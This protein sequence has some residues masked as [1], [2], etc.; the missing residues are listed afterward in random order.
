VLPAPLGFEWAVSHAALPT[1]EAPLGDDAVRILFSP[2]DAAGRAAIGRADVSLGGLVA[3][4]QPEP[5]LTPGPLGAFD[6]NGVTVS[7]LVDEGDRTLLY[8]TGW[9]LGV[10]V[11]FQLFAGCAVSTD[12]GA[13]FHRTSAAPLL[14][15]SA[16]D[17]FLTASPWVLVDEGVWRM[18][19]VSAVEWEAAA[20]GV[21]HRYHIRY[22]ESD[23]G[24][25]WRRDGRVAV[26]FADE[27]EFALSRPCV[28]KDGDVYR[29]W[30]AARGDAYRLAYAESK[31]GL[32]WERVDGVELVGD[33]DGWDAHMQAYPAVFDLGGERW[34]L[35]NGDDYGRT[36]IGLALMTA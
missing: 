11:P 18:W 8:Y 10:S 5:L 34:M 26:D 14:E 7:C 29:M 36:G 30:F 13:T 33:T 1:L 6:D 15:R 9:S 25:A 23:D 22:A 35:Y 24:L 4:V 32:E 21:R 2:R 17:P 27:S 16:V 28:V 19:Y 12:D 20:G 31:D 3:S